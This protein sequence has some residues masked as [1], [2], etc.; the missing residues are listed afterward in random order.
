MVPISR[1]SKFVQWEYFFYLRRL[2][3]RGLV[4]CI[5]FIDS[6]LGFHPRDSGVMQVG[7]TPR[8]REPQKSDVAEYDRLLHCLNYLACAGLR[9]QSTPYHRKTWSAEEGAG[10]PLF[11]AREFLA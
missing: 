9:L 4:F 5:L 2:T 6:G 1:E 10:A 8:E 3:P 11:V 7:G